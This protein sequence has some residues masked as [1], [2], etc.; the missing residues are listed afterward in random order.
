[1][2]TVGVDVETNS[3]VVAA[4]GPLLSEVESVVQE[5]DRRAADKPPESIAVFNLKRTEPYV[6]RDTLVNLLGDQVEVSE[7]SSSDSR[8][9]TSGRTSSGRTS[10]GRTAVPFTRQSGFGGGGSAVDIFSR[11]RAMQGQ[12][13]GGQTGRGSDRGRGGTDRSGRGGRGGR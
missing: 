12:T 9:R 1:M 4:P 10:G 6:I 5:L 7:T 11:M 8:G 13:G 2:M 3:L